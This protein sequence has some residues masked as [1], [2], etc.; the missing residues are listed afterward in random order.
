MEYFM[1]YSS[2]FRQCFIEDGLAAR[3]SYIEIGFD[4]KNKFKANNC[5]RIEIFS[6]EVHQTVLLVG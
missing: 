2:T 1:I 6:Y 3:P 4:R 5:P